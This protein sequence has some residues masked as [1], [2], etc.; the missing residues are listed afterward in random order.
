MDHVIPLCHISMIKWDMW[1]SLQG[2]IIFL[3][4]NHLYCVWIIEAFI[5]EVQNFRKHTR[6]YHLV[7]ICMYNFLVCYINLVYLEVFWQGVSHTHMAPTHNEE[8]SP[9]G[10]AP[11]LMDCGGKHIKPLSG[12]MLGICGIYENTFTV[13]E[14]VA[15]QTTSNPFLFD[16]T[17]TN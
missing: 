14:G 8:F 3:C 1:T 2:Y 11:I 5:W 17:N 13:D 4:S 7:Y 6:E 15:I 12:S 9:L 16:H 10:D